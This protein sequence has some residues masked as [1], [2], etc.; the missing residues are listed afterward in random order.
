MISRQITKFIK[1]YEINIIIKVLI[2]SDFL[3]WSANQLFAPILAIFITN[4]LY[5]GNVEVVGFSVGIYLFVKSIF[6]IPVGLFIDKRKGEIDGIYTAFF[7]TLLSGITILFF[8]Y[9]TQ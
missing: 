2:I 8:N 3:I 5:N 4:N 9:I 7:G 1:N 6:E